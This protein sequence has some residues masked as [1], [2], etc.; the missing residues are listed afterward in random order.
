[1]V[2]IALPLWLGGSYLACRSLF[3]S[4][5]RTRAERLDTLLDDL[6]ETCERHCA[7]APAAA[8]TE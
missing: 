4:R 3:R 2:P 6:V 1:L 7:D 5:A 8:A